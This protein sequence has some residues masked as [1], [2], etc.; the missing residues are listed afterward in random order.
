M[1]VQYA[2]MTAGGKGTLINWP[3]YVYIEQRLSRA[4][5]RKANLLIQV[6]CHFIQ[7]TI[8]Q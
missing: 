3:E 8:L 7:I 1:Q 5:S 6:C 2:S 4:I